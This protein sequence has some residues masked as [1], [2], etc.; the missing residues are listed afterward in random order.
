MKENVSGCFFSEHSVYSVAERW[1]ITQNLVSQKS[2]SVL[3]DA[4][5]LSQTYT[6]I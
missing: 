1:K 2:A 6:R 4:A 3:Q 5:K